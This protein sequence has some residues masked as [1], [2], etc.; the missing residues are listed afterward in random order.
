MFILNDKT[1]SIPLDTINLIALTYYS[2][3]SDILHIYDINFAFDENIVPL[4]TSV[5]ETKPNIIYAKRYSNINS[6]SLIIIDSLNIPNKS[7]LIFPSFF[8]DMKSSNLQNI[9][10]YNRHLVNSLDDS[11]DI[12]IRMYKL[13]SQ[14]GVFSNCILNEEELTIIVWN[15]EYANFQI[16][17]NKANPIKCQLQVN[18]YITE[19]NKLISTKLDTI[20]VILEKI[21]KIKHY[22]LN[23]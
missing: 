18:I 19:Y 5:L 10:G 9:Q 16:I 14:P 13:D 21:D 20:N 22:M 15:W 1:I 7:Q 6:E 12:L 3:K 2:A 17:I 4:C 23:I 11:N 8:H